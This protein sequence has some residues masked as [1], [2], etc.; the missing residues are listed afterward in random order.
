MSIVMFLWHFNVAIVLLDP[1]H[2]LGD[3][4]IACVWCLSRC[5]SQRFQSRFLLSISNILWYNIG[6]YF[7][8]RMPHLHCCTSYKKGFWL[9]R[10]TVEWFSFEFAIEN[11]S[12]HGWT[13]FECHDVSRSAISDSG[14]HCSRKSRGWILVIQ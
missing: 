6:V 12:V 4:K 7:F 8:W 3:K 13:K 5:L 1:F 11:W 2:T 14:C 10:W 9:G